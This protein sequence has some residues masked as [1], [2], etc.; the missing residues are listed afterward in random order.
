MKG[1]IKGNL[2]KCV[3]RDR[4]RP[5]TMLRGF[6]E[7]KFED[8]KFSESGTLQSAKAKSELSVQFELK[9]LLICNDDV[10]FQLHI[11]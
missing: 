11:I 1:C 3:M 10:T 2:F 5:L 4:N 9:S 8:Q 7:G 6:K